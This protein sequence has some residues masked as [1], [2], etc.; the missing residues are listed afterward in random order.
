MGRQAARQLSISPPPALVNVG[1]G[2]LQSSSLSS[3][4]LFGDDCAETARLSA[5]AAAAASAKVQTALT[6]T[7]ATN[8]GAFK[9]SREFRRAAVRSPAAVGRQPAGAIRLSHA[10]VRIMNHDEFSSFY[11]QQEQLAPRRLRLLRLQRR[12]APTL[13]AALLNGRRRL[14]APSSPEH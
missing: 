9:Q 5:A 12:R 10:A 3:P 7:A 8:D 11:C 6:A 14:D 13:S 2:A 1:R 4:R